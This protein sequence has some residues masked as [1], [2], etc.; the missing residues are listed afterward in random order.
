MR[1]FSIFA[2]ALATRPGTKP[3]APRHRLPARHAGGVPLYMGAL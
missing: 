2:I 1:P 3:H